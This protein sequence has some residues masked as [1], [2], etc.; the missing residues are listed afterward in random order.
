VNR[1]APTAAAETIDGYIA[2]FPLDVQ[3]Q[4]QQVRRAIAKAAPDAVAKVVEAKLRQAAAPQK[5][6]RKT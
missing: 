3:A 6:T 4:L 2:V 1:P 5:R